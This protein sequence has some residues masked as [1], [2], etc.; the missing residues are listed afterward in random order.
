MARSLGVALRALLLALVLAGFLSAPAGAQTPPAARPAAAQD[1]STDVLFVLDSSASMSRDDARGR[2]SDPQ[3]LRLSAVRAFVTL[4][5]PRMRLGLINL[6]DE[7]SGNDGLDR[8]TP[9][10]TGLLMPLTDASPQGRAQLLAAVGEVKTT[11]E[12]GLADGFTYMSKALDLAGRVM[13]GS[14]AQQRYVIV[15]TDGDVTGEDPRRWWGQAREMQA[16]GTRF[17]V[18]RLGRREPA[19]LTN[20]ELASLNEA[21]LPGGGAA[22]VVDRPED[23]LG[24]YL[25]TFVVLNRDA[26]LNALGPMSAGADQ[27]LMNVQDWMD[28]SEVDLL[29][30]GAG[31]PVSRLVS[32]RLGRDVLADVQATRS[33]DPNL[34]VLTLSRERLG[35]LEGRWLI[36]LGQA[37]Q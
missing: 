16:S 36:S 2:A 27:P 19:G 18:F 33:G 6:S 8:P 5:T 7:Y 13:S 1:L 26:Y 4:A 9:L 15:L 10:E 34:Q 32:E 22:R 30:S 3:R 25:Q 14:T 17:V 31:Q 24:Y 29:V 37:A 23:L 28:V 35:A 12:A 21:L 11:D 20:R